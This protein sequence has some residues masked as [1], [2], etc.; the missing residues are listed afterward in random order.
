MTMDGEFAVRMVSPPKRLKIEDPH[1]IDGSGDH[2][3]IK[4]TRSS[5]DI[6]DWKHAC[7]ICSDICHPSHRRASTK[8]S[9]SMVTNN[10]MYQQVLHAAEHKE[11]DTMLLRLRGIPH[12]DLVATEARYHRGRQCV[13]N[14]TR[15]ASLNTTPTQQSPHK[16]ILKKLISEID[17]DIGVDQKVFH[18]SALTQ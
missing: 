6:F 1:N 16:K 3:R 10:I 9:W 5:I 8:Y 12:G 2:I 4:A 7:F 13:L 17:H 15:T 18:L 14:Y 11:D